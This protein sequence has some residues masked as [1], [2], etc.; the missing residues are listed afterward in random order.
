M[1]PGFILCGMCILMIITG[2]DHM[3]TGI[4]KTKPHLDPRSVP[5]WMMENTIAR[6]GLGLFVILLAG[7]LL[8]LMIKY[9]NTSH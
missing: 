4:K 7:G 3:V 6:V 9:P 1:I 5:D 8:F 2:I